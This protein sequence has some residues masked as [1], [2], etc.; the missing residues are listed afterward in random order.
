MHTNVTAVGSSINS[1][2]LQYIFNN[3]EIIDYKPFGKITYELYDERG[4]LI[5]GGGPRRL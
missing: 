1:I 2:A 5:G 4:D 3:T